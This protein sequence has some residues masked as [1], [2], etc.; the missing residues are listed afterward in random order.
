MNV[1]DTI[2]RFR[3]RHRRGG[4]FPPGT[5][6]TKKTVV[7][8]IDPMDIGATPLADS[9]QPHDQ[10]SV[11]SENGRSKWSTFC[12]RGNLETCRNGS[13]STTAG[14]VDRAEKA[15]SGKVQLKGGSNSSAGGQT[16]RNESPNILRAAQDE[17]KGDRGQGTGEFL[18]P[19][20]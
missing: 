2:G 6:S 20:A 12:G 15:V 3:E 13:P 7:Q 9:A 19:V 16:F 1:M 5:I 18:A 4:S 8:I 17:W 10:E 11:P 14:S